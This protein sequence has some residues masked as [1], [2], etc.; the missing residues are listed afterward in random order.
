MEQ[1]FIAIVFWLNGETV[2]LPGWY[3]YPME[4]R[5]RCEN[6]L[7]LLDE[8]AESIFSNRIE[9]AGIFCGTQQEIQREISILNDEQV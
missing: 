8:Q 1:I 9:V 4:N 3:P 6:A 7:I 5:E 2:F